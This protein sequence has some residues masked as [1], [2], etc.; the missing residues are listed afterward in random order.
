MQRQEERSAG[1][2]TFVDK[3]CE[4]CSTVDEE[5]ASEVKRVNDYY[6]ELEQKMMKD[7]MP[8]HT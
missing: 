3:M 7:E 2:S 4:R 5:F 1:W 8:S 6:R